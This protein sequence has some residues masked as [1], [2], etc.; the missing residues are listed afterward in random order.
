MA[1]E[2]SR[3]LLTTLLALL[4]VTAPAAAAPLV[5]GPTGSPLHV[6]GSDLEPRAGGPVLPAG[7]TAT[8]VSPDRRRIAA[9]TPTR[10]VVFARGSGRRLYSFSSRGATDA[11][12][13]TRGRL[14]TL[15][16]SRG[17]V[18]RSVALPSGSVG[19][20]VRLPERLGQELSGHNVRVLVR[21]RTGFRVD[22][23]G[24]D[25]TRRKR[26][27][28]PVPE[29]IDPGLARASLRDGLVALSYTTGAVAP[30]AHAL[31]RLGGASRQ[32]ELAG[33]VYT[34]VTPDILVDTT[35]HIARI[36]RAAGAV[37]REIE[38][39]TG[40][41]VVPFRAGVAVGL[42]RAVYD[43]DLN[44]DASNPSAD[45]GASAPVALGGRLYGL[46]LRC[47]PQGPVHAAV[48]VDA[49]TGK[50]VTRHDGPFSIGSLGERLS[51]PGED[52]CD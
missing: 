16:G 6:L 30:Y 24:A 35:G 39:E 52:G 41:W 34:F 37:V 26:Y 17:E 9:L 5:G 22:V 43:H 20:Q 44:L 1:R 15:G 48:A 45:R 3:F 31:V 14:I 10:I 7:T 51:P 4:A 29:G 2:M 18:L 19:K 25:G 21:T 36:D 28:I 50:V 47:T 13:P 27:R 12:W 40:Q 32:V 46:T 42:G 23:F 11:L 38:I 8:L 49:L 33:A